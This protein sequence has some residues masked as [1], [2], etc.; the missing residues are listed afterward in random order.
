MRPTLV[1][2]AVCCAAVLAFC[3]AS[4]PAV[5]APTRARVHAA[6]S[7]QADIIPPCED[8]GRR[9]DPC[10]DDGICASGPSGPV[11]LKDV[12]IVLGVVIGGVWVVSRR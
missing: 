8:C 5:A 3:V 12:L 1:A 10:L 11:D 4:P 9:Y 2:V 7:L 6:R